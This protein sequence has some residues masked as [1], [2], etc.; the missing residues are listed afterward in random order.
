MRGAIFHVTCEF[1][2]DDQLTM[3]HKHTILIVD[4]EADVVKSLQD[5]LRLEYRVLGATSALRAME[6]LAGQDVHVVLSD[7]RMPGM[8]GVE[9]LG[10]V[11]QKS[12]DTIR[13]LLTGYSDLQAV[14]D[15]INIGNV[16]RYIPKPWSVEELQACLRDACERYDLN[17]ASRQMLLNPDSGIAKQILT[18]AHVMQNKELNQLL[19][20][21]ADL[22]GRRNLGASLQK[23]ASMV[24]ELIKG[25][26]CSIRLLDDGKKE[27]LLHSSVNLSPAYLA[28]GPVLLSRSELDA[29]AIRTGK[30]VYV[31]DH[32]SDPAVP[33]SQQARSEGL[34]S[35]LYVPMLYR[36]RAIGMI[37]A[38]MDCVHEFTPLEISML[39]TL[40]AESAAAVMNDR[41]H[42]QHAQSASMKRSLAMAAQV[43]R[44]MIPAAVPEIPGYEIGAIFAPR[45]ELAGDFY[46]FIPLPMNNL[47]LAVCDVM[48]KG[49]RASLLMA[50]IRASLRAHATNIYDMRD[51]I[52]RVNRDLCGEV[53]AGDFATLFYGVLNSLQ[54]R[55]TYTNAGHCMPLWVRN[56]VV[57]NLT[58]GGMALGIVPTA[59]YS[60]EELMLESGD[61]LVMFTDGLVDSVNAEEE[62]FGVTR[63]ERLSL[64]AVEK[65]YPAE[66]IAEHILQGFAEF[67]GEQVRDDDMTLVTVR[68]K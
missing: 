45:D 2:R 61:V 63:I 38:Y 5:F 26:A 56:G 65:N 60:I 10:R 24:T 57:R 41:L 49:V 48:G 30:T 35:A 3:S 9:F 1:L 23:V 33:Y 42:R 31:A 68:V 12:P 25:K 47:G 54:R 53:E 8:S 55:F 62:A 21:T 36:G 59:S 39:E 22:A 29:R 50:A 64:E 32:R 40:A 37:H 67:A 34:V 16:Y 6:L 11:R 51:V 19:R 15:A 13:V 18:Y 27:L 52:S 14:V 4:D 58:A 28:K 46:D 43:Q 17:L 44:R 66:K 20:L 7:Q